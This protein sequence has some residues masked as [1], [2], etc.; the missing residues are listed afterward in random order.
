MLKVEV[1]RERLDEIEIR[2]QVFSDQ[3]P[4]MPCAKD[5]V[6]GFECFQELKDIAPT[7]IIIRSAQ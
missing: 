3:S 5:V 4:I 6:L 7:L 1:V 2:D